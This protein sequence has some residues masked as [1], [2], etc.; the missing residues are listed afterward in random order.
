MSNLTSATWKVLYWMLIIHKDCIFCRIRSVISISKRHIISLINLVMFQWHDNTSSVFFFSIFLIYI[1]SNS[2]SAFRNI[3]NW[4]NK[5]LR[6]V[7]NKSV[8]LV[9]MIDRVCNGHIKW[10]LISINPFLNELFSFLN[11]SF[12]WVHYLLWINA[13]ILCIIQWNIWKKSK[14]K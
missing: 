2:L 4:V 6:K 7:R 11:G 12:K 9:D 10:A 14:K 8:Q 13:N 3:I 5:C 1:I